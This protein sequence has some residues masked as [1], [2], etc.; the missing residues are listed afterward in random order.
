LYKTPIPD[1]MKM[2]ELKAYSYLKYG[3]LFLRIGLPGEKEEIEILPADMAIRGYLTPG[4]LGQHINEPELD[5]YFES[6]RDKHRRWRE[7]KDLALHRKKILMQLIEREKVK[8]K[9][10][11]VES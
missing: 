6:N 8:F 11:I 10:N 5:E 3:T 2:G 1:P 7:T 9:A 4:Y